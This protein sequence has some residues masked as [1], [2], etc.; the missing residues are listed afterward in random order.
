ME[1]L[2]DGVW[3]G[4]SDGGKDEVRNPATGEL[5]DTVP[6]ATFA[7]VERAVGA[8][9]SGRR[10]MARL[11][12]HER[13]AIL[14]R[15]AARIETEQHSLANLLC[16]E[17]GK[18]RREIVS[19]I[20]AA[21]RI[22]RGY[23]E[24]AKRIFGKAIPLDSVPGR[25]TSLAVTIRTPLG[26]VVAIVPFNYPVELWSHK[27]AGA[28]AAGNAV[29]TKPPE[30]CP[31]TVI[32][33]ARFMEEAGLP[34][35]AHQVLTGPGETVGAA[36]VRADGV[37]MVAMT[38]STSAGRHI[39]RAAAE[40]LKKVHLELGGNDA[41]IVCGDADPQTVASDLIAGRFT[42]GNGQIC[43]AVKRV[44]VDEAIHDDLLTA[45]VAKTKS[46]RV[47]DPLSDDTDV[48]PLISEEAAATVEAQVKK[49]VAEG[50]KIVAG[51]T[52]NG[53]FYAPTI[54]TEVSEGNVAFR[55]EIFGPVL[56]LTPFSKFDDAL[57]LANDSKYGL[58][59]AIYTHDIGRIMRAFHELEVGTVIV[60]HGT[61]IRVENLP[62]GGTK[63]SGNA[64]E[65][66]HETLLDMTE[67]RTLLMADVF[68]AAEA[69]E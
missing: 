13:A 21:V 7:D 63:L 42:S 57:Q 24:E 35:A 54:L 6:R 20:A 31:L 60:N 40:T 22:W 58:Q 2:I 51:G 66:L 46:L 10:R 43:C 44:L 52:R 55:D 61:N 37:Q 50:A 65:G 16:R 30:Q 56:S 28:L 59:A 26:V 4:A 33:I 49:A 45:L 23:A 67:Q 29:I 11:P 41:T 5:I 1:H 9:Q 68:P 3:T 19:E 8:A 15:V 47:G 27:A 69:A 36:L 62:F 38:G 32:Q 14:M 34:R 39:A 25:E 48:G 18:T 17:N 12:A 53:T 64:R